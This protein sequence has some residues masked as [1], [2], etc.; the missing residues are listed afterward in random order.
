MSRPTY[1][2]KRKWEPIINQQTGYNCFFCKR[3]DLPL[4][5]GHL[6][7]DKND[8]RPENIA[9][10]CH[11]CN[12]KMKDD[13]DMKF[14]ALEQLERNE[15]STLACGKAYESVGTTEDLTSCQAISKIN[16]T[17]T[18]QYITEQLRIDSYLLV[19]EAVK[20]I[21]GITR[22]LNN[23]GSESAIYRYLRILTSTA[24]PYEFAS[25]ENG[26]D[27]IRRKLGI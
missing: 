14:I 10:M 21:N 12:C 27:I 7:G 16:F 1:T 20:E 25:N 18:E 22:K 8:S 13:Y 26:Q 15:S 19:R 4:E 6:N 23:T 11:P 2:Q 9:K 17:I 3:Y 24:Y 5:Y